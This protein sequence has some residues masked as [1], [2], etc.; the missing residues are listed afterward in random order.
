MRIV[1]ILF[2]AVAAVLVASPAPAQKPKGLSATATFGAGA[3]AGSYAGVL[4]GAFRADL[5]RTP[6]VE[7]V[8]FAA[9]FAAADDTL[10]PVGDDLC[11]EA[12]LLNV[13]G[14]ST[15]PFGAFAAR[16]VGLSFLD[17]RGYPYTLQYGDAQAT[18][19]TYARG[20]C[21]QAPGASGCTAAAFDT[22]VDSVPGQAGE[23]RPTGS[24]ARLSVQIGRRKPVVV[25]LY[26]VPFT[27]TITT[28]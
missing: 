18:E 27:L 6:V 23:L 26:A 4:D 7:T 15:L 14:V 10:E 9:A 28:P 25:G 17:D 12:T 13:H 8:C 20:T 22:D 21:Q 5:S 11:F 1:V 3:I 2:V 24:I 16:Q 19:P